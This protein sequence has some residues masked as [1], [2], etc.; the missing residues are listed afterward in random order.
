MREW[1]QE[2]RRIARELEK[3]IA[4]QYDQLRRESIRKAVKHIMESRQKSPGLFF[5]KANP[6]KQTVSDKLEWLKRKDGTF[7]SSGDEI[8]ASV[9][10]FI[11]D[12]GSRKV[13]IDPQAQEPWLEDEIYERYRETFDKKHEDLTKDISLSELRCQLR[14]MANGKAVGPDTCPADLFKRLPDHALQ[15]FCGLMNHW[16]KTGEIP[17]SWRESYSYMLHKGGPAYDMNNY[18]CIALLNTGY[19][20]MLSIVNQRLIRFLESNRL[21]SNMQGGFRSARSTKDKILLLHTTIRHSSSLKKHLHAVYL[22][23]KKAYDSVEHEALWLALEKMHFPIEITR[24]LKNCYS[25]VSTVAFTPYGETKPIPLSRGIRQGCPISPLLFNLLLE[26]LYLWLERKYQNR[27]NTILAYVDDGA[28]VTSDFQLLQDIFNDM[29][30]FYNFNGIAIGLDSA[31]KQKTAYTGT[32]GQR[33]LKFVDRAGKTQIVPWLPPEEHYKYLGIW[34]SLTQDWKKQEAVLTAKIA[35]YAGFLKHKCFTEDQCVEIFNKLVAPAVAYS[36]SVIRFPKETLTAWDK[37]IARTINIKGRRLQK[38]SR[39]VL[40]L[41][42]EDGGKGLVSME[43]LQ[44][45]ENEGTYFKT[46]LQGN[47]TQLTKLI[48]ELYFHSEDAVAKKHKR[49]LARFNVKAQENRHA[50]PGSEHVAPEEVISDGELA[51]LLKKFKYSQMQSLFPHGRLRHYGDLHPDDRAKIPKERYEKLR[52]LCKPGTD[53]INPIVATLCCIPIQEV[54]MEGK[55]YDDKSNTFLAWADGSQKGRAIAGYGVYYGEGNGDDTGGRINFTSS[56]NAAEMQSVLHILLEFPKDEP[57]TLFTDSQYA[58]DLITGKSRCRDG[59]KAWLL[60]ISSALSQRTAQ[61]RFKKV[62]SHLLDRLPP[63]RVVEKRVE[64]LEKMKAKYGEQAK[65][66]LEGNKGADKLASV[67]AE[68]PIAEVPVLHRF[69]AEVVLARYEEQKLSVGGLNRRW[70]KPIELET[71]VK[72]LIREDW[73]K[74]NRKRV[75]DQNPKRWGHLEDP[76]ID[77]KASNLLNCDLDYNLD[78]LKKFTHKSR[79]GQFN[80]KAKVMDRKER[81]GYWAK[82]YQN[83]PIKDRKCPLCGEDETEDSCHLHLRRHCRYQKGSTL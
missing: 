17:Q 8:R 60:A 3:D 7:T 53:V 22:D 29:V 23:L 72:Q 77:I 12:I 15:T 82:V 35:R 50:H 28:V 73:M 78:S 56:N 10:D 51:L 55:R 76:E 21:L 14:R 5:K 80:E 2:V 39:F 42:P 75:I 71:D 54:T 31:T 47:D 19:K 81:G 74:K 32:E 61:T 20:I 64:R 16:L 24:L 36:M 26:P 83:S 46:A 40:Y 13:R 52:K 6:Y 18:R 48:R 70:E 41:K 25:D 1:F 27:E 37:A 65:E 9:E 43:H 30:R 66:I 67:A 79:R 11:G 38:A 4:K 69:A 68:M 63:A 58:K 49:K 57:L 59:N 34:I 62:F 45:T 33:E 44:D